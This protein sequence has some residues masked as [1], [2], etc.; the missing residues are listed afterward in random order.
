MTA[1]ATVESEGGTFGLSEEEKASLKAE[2]DAL[3]KSDAVIVK[4]IEAKKED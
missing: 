4:T 2:I 3:Q 1:Q